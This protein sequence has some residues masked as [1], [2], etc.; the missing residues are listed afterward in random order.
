MVVGEIV[1]GDQPQREA[2]PGS[3]LPVPPPV[4]QR[5]QRL[6]HLHILTRAKHRCSPAIG[7]AD[8]SSSSPKPQHRSSAH[9]PLSV[10]RLWQGTDPPT[11]SA[12]TTQ[13]PTERSRTGRPIRMC[14]VLRS[15]EGVQVP[16]DMRGWRLRCRQPGRLGDRSISLD[17][18]LGSLRKRVQ[19]EFSSMFHAR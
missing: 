8:R 15:L 19:G 4:V 10:K 2:V 13:H 7:K 5:E 11:R 1:V 12:S 17:S 6:C 3:S 18:D 14:A 9:A 16:V